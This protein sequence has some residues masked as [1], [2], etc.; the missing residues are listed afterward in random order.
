[1]DPNIKSEVFAKTKLESNKKK[2]SSRKR[3]RSEES[4]SSNN[5][6][7]EEQISSGV[8]LVTEAIPVLLPT[9]L[10]SI[11][12][13]SIEK[14]TFTLSGALTKDVSAGLVTISGKKL[15]FVEPPEARIPDKKWR[16]HVFKGDKEMCEPLR[17][18]RQSSFLIGKD[19]EI[20]E[21]YVEHP[22]CSKQHA[23]IQFR[24]VSKNK[25]D[26]MFSKKVSIIP[27][28]L[29][30]ESTNGSY[31]NGKKLESSRYVELRPSDVLRFG[32]SARE[33]VL[34]HEDVTETS[35]TQE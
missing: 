33:Y 29:D 9:R 6:G 31:L 12:K 19:K 25:D 15:K 13:T 14:P 28:I 32:E 5:L 35:L 30:L 24:L 20:A 27:Y 11:T 2:S 8:P 3:F 26:D 16:L 4:L 10:E 7:N 23:V 22:S 21:I 34:L 17:L 1:M 18:H